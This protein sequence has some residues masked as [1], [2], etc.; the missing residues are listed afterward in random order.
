MHPSGALVNKKAALWNLILSSRVLGRSIRTTAV[1][2]VCRG[3][4]PLIHTHRFFSSFGVTDGGSLAYWE[5]RGGLNQK[6]ALWNLILSY[7]A[8]I[9]ALG[10]AAGIGPEAFGLSR[11]TIAAAMSERCSPVSGHRD[12]GERGMRRLYAY[13]S[14]WVPL[15]F[16]ARPSPSLSLSCAYSFSLFKR[17]CDCSFF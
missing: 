8:W 7:L 16:P 10:Q 17:N 1:K 9:S 5:E 11:M 3:Y 15:G 4:F 14:A 12:T 6:A 2:R 13:P